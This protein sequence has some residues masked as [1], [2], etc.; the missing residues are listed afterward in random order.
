MT[1]M[2]ITLFQIDFIPHLLL[3]NMLRIRPIHETEVKKTKKK[4]DSINVDENN[5]KPSNFYT[6]VL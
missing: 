5:E 1:V 2:K 4:Q 6:Q 3:F